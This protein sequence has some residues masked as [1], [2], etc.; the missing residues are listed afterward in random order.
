VKRRDDWVGVLYLEHG[1]QVRSVLRRMGIDSAELPDLVQ[2]VFMAA[3]RR[4]AKLPRDAEGAKRW[5]LEA[6]RKHAANWHRLIRHH[7]EVL[8][9]H[10]LVL[11]T[12]AEP[13]DPEAHL[14][15]RDLLLRALGKLDEVERQILVLY[16][17]EGEPLRELGKQLGIT[18]SGAHIRL[19]AA[20]ERM[21]MLVRRY[22][23]E[24]CQWRCGIRHSQKPEG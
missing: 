15:L 7:Y 23:S 11:N 12:P 19:Q 4:R 21:Q 3:H 20:K 17:L 10:V 6:A 9:C 2:K 14:V 13:V 18:K 8:G 16:Y 24:S 5:L 1:K 22:K